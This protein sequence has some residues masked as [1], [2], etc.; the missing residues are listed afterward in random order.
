[1]PRT[2]NDLEAFEAGADEIEARDHLALGK[3]EQ[4][5]ATLLMFALLRVPRLVRW[6]VVRGQAPWGGA[7]FSLPFCNTRRIFMGRLTR[8]GIRTRLSGFLRVRKSREA[9][10]RTGNA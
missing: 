3:D 9:A 5:T 7:A 6:G 4:N 8:S 2:R 1:M 10:W